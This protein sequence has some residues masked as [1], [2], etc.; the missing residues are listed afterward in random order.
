MSTEDRSTTPAFASAFPTTLRP[1][2]A[3]LKV[4]TAASSSGEWLVYGGA[5]SM[6][7]YLSRPVAPNGLRVTGS[8]RG[9]GINCREC[10]SLRFELRRLGLSR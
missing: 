10:Q 6:D 2:A 5:H 3:P 4:G 9:Q 7:C 8:Y 1:D